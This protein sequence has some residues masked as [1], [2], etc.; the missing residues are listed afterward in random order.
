MFE[1]SIILLAGTTILLFFLVFGFYWFSYQ[2]SPISVIKY[3]VAEVG[4]SVGIYATIPPNTYNTIAKQLTEKER[5]L[6]EKEIE[7]EQKENLLK[8]LS[9]KK[10]KYIF[11]GLFLMVF[12][13]FIM[14][15]IN[16]YL[17]FKK[18]RQIKS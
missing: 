1:K 7:L 16:F 14:I 10:N 5:K 9:A 13:L 11:G 3:L 6:Q 8:E 17:D 12:I 4:S 18:R 2:I 15:S